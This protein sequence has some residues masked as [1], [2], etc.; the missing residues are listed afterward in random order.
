MARFAGLFLAA[1]ATATPATAEML[2]SS[3]PVEVIDVGGQ[4]DDPPDALIPS[5]NASQGVLFREFAPIPFVLRG[6]EIPGQ[7]G[8]GIGIRVRLPGYTTGQVVTV[9]IE[10]PVGDVGYWEEEIE[11]GGELY[12]GR[13]PAYGEPLPRGRYL[14]QAYDGNRPLFTY[15]IHVGR[16]E[17]ATLCVPDVS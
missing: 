16:Q 11:G 13:V 1:L 12:F 4:C 10:P 5:P 6:D 14:L 15:A 7:V 9:R 8:L 17:D 3:V 2:R